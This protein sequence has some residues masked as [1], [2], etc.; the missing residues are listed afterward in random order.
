[1]L[2]RTMDCH[3]LEEDGGLLIAYNFSSSRKYLNR[4]PGET[5][6]VEA[7]LTVFITPG[8]LGLTEKHNDK[9]L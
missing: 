3:P 4:V 9:K 5:S 8:L 2:Y 6:R 7:D 1:M